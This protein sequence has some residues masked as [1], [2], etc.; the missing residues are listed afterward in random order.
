MPARPTYSLLGVGIHH[1]LRNQV[2]VLVGEV[3]D[4]QHGQGPQ[5]LSELLPGQHSITIRVEQVE[6][7]LE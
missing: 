5:T 7:V 4:V 2:Q 1:V 6:S 3:L